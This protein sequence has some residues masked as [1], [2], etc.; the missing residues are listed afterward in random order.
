MNHR[1]LPP[2]ADAERQTMAE[3]IREMGLY[4][5]AATLG[6]LMLMKHR[7]R[8]GM[9]W[10]HDQA[11]RVAQVARVRRGARRCWAYTRDL[12]GGEIGGVQDRQARRHHITFLLLPEVDGVESARV[13]DD[14]TASESLLGRD[15]TGGDDF[16]LADKTDGDVLDLA[17]ELTAVSLETWHTE[18]TCEDPRD[19][20]SE[21]V[22]ALRSRAAEHP[23]MAAEY[24]AL[25]DAYIEADGHVPTIAAALRVQ[26]RTIHYR[27]SALREWVAGRPVDSRGRHTEPRG[28]YSRA[29]REEAARRGIT[30]LE[31]YRLLGRRL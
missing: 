17:D 27:L 26:D 30:P 31:L 19:D 22:A 25:L 4:G 7:A 23:Y 15:T 6:F 1:D 18:S 9:E 3:L 5:P 10:T 20:A 8:Y 21:R 12:G 29:H 14:P 28:R 16:D 11:M 13:H 24:V 2:L